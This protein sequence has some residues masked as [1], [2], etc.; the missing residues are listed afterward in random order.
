MEIQKGEVSCMAHILVI[1]MRLSS[2]NVNIR[3]RTCSMRRCS[4]ISGTSEPFP[5]YRAIRI[6]CRVPP[7]TSFEEEEPNTPSMN[8]KNLP[9]INSREGLL[10][11]PQRT[12]RHQEFLTALCQVEL[13][14]GKREQCP[15]S[16]GTI[17]LVLVR[18]PEFNGRLQLFQMF[19]TKTAQTKSLIFIFHEKKIDSK[20]STLPTAPLNDLRVVNGIEGHSSSQKRVHQ[21]QGY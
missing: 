16:I 2:F 14:Q 18:F 21:L 8:R 6:E 12:F 17:S 20:N 1:S 10:K 3:R 13:E 15:R 19:Q 11:I 7:P 9:P 4:S 5:E